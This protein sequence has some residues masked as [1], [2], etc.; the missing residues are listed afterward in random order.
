MQDNPP[1]TP[2]TLAISDSTL[3]EVRNLTQVEI[4]QISH[5]ESHKDKTLIT[6]PN[7]SL[8][9]GEVG[10]ITRDLESYQAIV[11]NVEIIHIEGVNAIAKVIPFNQL[12]QPYLPTPRLTPQ[13]G[14]KVIFRI[15]NNKAFLIAPDKYS[16]DTISSQ[17]SFIDFIN[18]D[19]LMG[20]LNSQGKHDPTPKNLPKACNEYA[21]GLVFIVGS[22]TLAVLNCQNLSTIYQYDIV[23]P[24]SITAQSPFYT[25]IH[26]DGGGSLTYVF[27]SKKSKDYFGYYDS[28]I[29]AGRQSE[30]TLSEKKQ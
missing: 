27:A 19:L 12:K 8:R 6:L 13:E 22:K 23:L 29:H 1:K 7:M 11:A 10:I 18:S 28:L 20:F 16:Y 2:Q 24:D 9:I 30:N 17:Y 25:R 4:T 21:A 15:Y 3:T 5:I 14:D 26:F